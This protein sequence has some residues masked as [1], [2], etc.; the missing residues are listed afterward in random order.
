MPGAFGI[1]SPVRDGAKLD[2]NAML[3]AGILGRYLADVWER[4]AAAAADRIG[5]GKA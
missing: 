3:Q 2:A 4:A 1:S 5:R